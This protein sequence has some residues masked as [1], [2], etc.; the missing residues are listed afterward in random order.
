MAQAVLFLASGSASY[1]TGAAL[2][3]DGGQMAS[4]FGTWNDAS[5]YIRWPKME[6][7]ATHRPVL[8]EVITTIPVL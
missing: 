1:I 7:E 2:P 8:T 4:K 3:V 5:G 6:S